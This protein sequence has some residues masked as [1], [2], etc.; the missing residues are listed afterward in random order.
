MNHENNLSS[1]I[2]KKGS[3]KLLEEWQ[4]ESPAAAA[5]VEFFKNKTDP[6]TWKVFDNDSKTKTC[7]IVGLFPFLIDGESPFCSLKIWG[8]Q[9]FKRPSE[10]CYLTLS[11]Y[12]REEYCHQLNLPELRLQVDY[13]RDDIVI[14][15]KRDILICDQRD[16][17]NNQRKISP[18]FNLF[19]DNAIEH[20]GL[21][22]K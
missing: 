11:F 14:C 18:E 2:F 20:F 5:L 16:I 21:Y 15:D 3:E 7:R 8:S 13:H 4:G 6:K 17:L 22:S 10:N 1:D 12:K 19:I 9:D